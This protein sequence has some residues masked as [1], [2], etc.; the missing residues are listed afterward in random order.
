MSLLSL[1]PA[2]IGILGSLFGGGKGK[3]QERLPD[4]MRTPQGNE[5][6]Q[7]L[8]SMYKQPSA[9]NY[10]SNMGAYTLM[11]KFYPGSGY[12]MPQLTTPTTQPTGGYQAKASG[13]SAKLSKWA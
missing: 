6:I 8:M 10:M 7:Y 11:D 2:G 9:G 4:I 5:L 13:G 3:A 1:M 12:Q